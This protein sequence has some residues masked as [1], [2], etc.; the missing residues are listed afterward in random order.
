M[1]VFI[2]FPK[3]FTETQNWMKYFS[4]EANANVF[5]NEIL[6]CELRTK[7]G[8]NSSWLKSL[9]ILFYFHCFVFKV[10]P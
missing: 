9:M 6:Y 3:H 2:Y 10:W 8:N 1:Y 7:S 4:L 5:Q